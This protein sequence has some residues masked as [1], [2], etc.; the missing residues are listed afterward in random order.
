MS[1]VDQA[2]VK[3]GIPKKDR[4]QS[5]VYLWSYPNLEPT[6]FKQGMSS[7]DVNSRIGAACTYIDKKPTEEYLYL[8][9]EGKEV[10]REIESNF[11]IYLRAAGA[12][13]PQLEPGGGRKRDSEVFAEPFPHSKKQRLLHTAVDELTPRYTRVKLPKTPDAAQVRNWREHLEC[14]KRRWR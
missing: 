3:A 13:R 2:L 10:I 8:V 1:S 7:C 5:G 12:T 6:Y 4:Q 9:D 14:K 11:K